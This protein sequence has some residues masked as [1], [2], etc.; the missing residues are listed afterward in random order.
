M[1]LITF[2]PMYMKLQSTPSFTTLKTYLRRGSHVFELFITSG[3]TNSR[4][5]CS[6][7]VHNK[8]MKKRRTQQAVQTYKVKSTIALRLCNI[9]KTSWSDIRQEI[10]HYSSKKVIYNEFGDVVHLS[11][12]GSLAG[13]VVEVFCLLDVACACSRVVA[14][15]C[16]CGRCVRAVVHGLWFVE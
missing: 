6:H 12:S 13:N 7:V 2:V 15:G 8:I 11:H 5:L 10:V 9:R 14:G 4:C 1:A 3:N 16:G